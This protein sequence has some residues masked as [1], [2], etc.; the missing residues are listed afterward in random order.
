MK[1][2]VLAIAV[3]ALSALCAAHAATEGE[4]DFICPVDG[5]AFTQKLPPAGTALGYMLDMQPFGDIQTPAPLPVC[6]RNGFVIYKDTFSAA[7]M[8][9]AIAVLGQPE[10]KKAP[11]HYRAYLL[12]QKIGE[13]LESQLRMLQ[14]AS[15]NGPDSYR[16]Q[17]LRLLAPVLA[18]DKL[19]DKARLHHLLLKA[20]FERRLGRF[21]QAQQTLQQAE[22]LKP[23]SLKFYSDIIQCQ[24]S[25]MQ[26]NNRK[27]A[28][29]PNEKFSCGQAVHVQ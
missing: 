3:L 23:G 28:P 29:M 25:L 27:T 19:T 14:E 21:A 7:E 2:G 1:R 24:R 20:E 11:T 9:K 8:D 17:V 10:Y 4:E 5:V 22:S 15:W 18:Q 16:E 12:M 13:P 26:Q 6:P